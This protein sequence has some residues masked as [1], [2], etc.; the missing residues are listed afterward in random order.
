MP[1]IATETTAFVHCLSTP[2]QN[3][4]LWSHGGEPDGMCEV[5]KL[6]STFTTAFLVV[7]LYVWH[8]RKFE[9]AQMTNAVL[10]RDTIMSSGIFV[11][12][13]VEALFYAVHAPAFVNLEFET[14]YFDLQQSRWLPTVITSDELCTLVMIATRS[15][16]VVRTL[17]Y[18]SG[19]ESRQTRGYSNMNKLNVTTSMSMRMI[20]YRFPLE[21]MVTQRVVSES[22]SDQSRAPVSRV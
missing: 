19:V 13:V 3:Y 10:Q 6:G 22:V 12:F 9:H 4:T 2:W 14:H 8:R 15:W 7:F 20:Y 1:L 21:L 5:L 18:L 17:R 11:E 16:L